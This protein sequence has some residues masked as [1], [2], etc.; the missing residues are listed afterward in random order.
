[1]VD[2]ATQPL[3]VSRGQ[4]SKAL[5]IGNLSDKS[6]EAAKASLATGVQNAE[7]QHLLDTWD[8]VIYEGKQDDETPVPAF[9][10][11]YLVPSATSRSEQ[12]ESSLMDELL[13]DMDW[14]ADDLDEGS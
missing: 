8:P 12:S 4:N 9:I 14:S 2:H 3:S 7:R 13:P 11:R 1:M 10:D 5:G 6:P